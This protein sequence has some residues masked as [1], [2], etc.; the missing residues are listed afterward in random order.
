MYFT[1][2]KEYWDKSMAA[3]PAS[4]ISELFTDPPPPL[5]LLAVDGH[6]LKCLAG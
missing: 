6:T 5:K 3:G 4:R 1:P 2:S